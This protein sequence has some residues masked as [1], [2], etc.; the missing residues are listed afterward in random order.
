MI[1]EKKHRLEKDCYK[2]EKIVSFTSCIKQ[3]TNV[4]VCKDL[5]NEFE[6]IL[7]KELNRFECDSYIHLFMPDH[8]H[9]IIEGKNENSDVIKVMEMFKQKTGYWFSNNGKI[10]KWQKDY[11]DHIIRDQEDLKKQIYYILEN[12]VRAG[13]CKHWKEYRFIGSTIYDFDEF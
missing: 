7:I 11:Y 8:I 5:F 13:I 1:R 6:K 10:A 3:R 2:G 9:F 12:P 4:F